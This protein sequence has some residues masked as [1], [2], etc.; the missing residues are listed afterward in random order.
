MAD[1]RQQYFIAIYSCQSYAPRNERAVHIINV[2]R[3]YYTGGG[4]GCAKRRYTLYLP[5]RKCR[6][7]I[8][9]QRRLGEVKKLI[10][11]R[12]LI[13]HNMTLSYRHRCV[14]AEHAPAAKR[15]RLTRQRCDVARFAFEIGQTC[16]NNVIM[17]TYERVCVCLSTFFANIKLSNEKKNR[18]VLALVN[19][20]RPQL[21][22][23]RFFLLS[24]V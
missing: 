9:Y 18:R 4:I 22:K 11:G 12:D 2:I 20:Q 14:C 6:K 21:K 16:Q 1:A 10:H 24:R 23:S 8:I 19:Q 3:T 13:V 7:S 17:C 15:F 5:V